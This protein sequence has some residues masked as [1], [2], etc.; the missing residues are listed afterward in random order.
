MVIEGDALPSPF[1]EN[2]THSLPLPQKNPYPDPIHYLCSGTMSGCGVALSGTATL[3]LSRRIR[4]FLKYCYF[5]TET[6]RNNVAFVSRNT[7]G[8]LT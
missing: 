3:V 8:Y 2:P 5:D 4:V 6:D 7:G 1:P